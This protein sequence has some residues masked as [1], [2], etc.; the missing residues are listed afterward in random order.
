MRDMRKL[1]LEYPAD[2][3]NTIWDTHPVHK[4]CIMS[5]TRNF[6][7]AHIRIV[8]ALDPRWKSCR[9]SLDTGRLTLRGTCTMPWLPPLNNQCAIQ[10]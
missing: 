9:R 4:A 6:F 8:T 2:T 5:A 3:Q 10:D 7:E 1:V